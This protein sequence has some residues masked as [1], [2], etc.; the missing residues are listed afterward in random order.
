[1]HQFFTMSLTKSSLERIATSFLSAF[2][3][4]SVDDHIALRAPLCIHIFAPSSLNIAPKTNA[5]FAAHVTNNLLPLLERF[6]VTAKETHINETGRQITIWATG[7]PEFKKEAMGTTP[8]EAWNYTNE[9]IFMLDV[10]ED[11]K[12]KK[13]VEFLDSSSTEKLRGAILKARANVGKTG[14][15]W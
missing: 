8:A 2:D 11:G 4:L 12:I 6:P 14:A 5:A 1:V 15:A 7:K 9:Y 13:I 3:N 10:N